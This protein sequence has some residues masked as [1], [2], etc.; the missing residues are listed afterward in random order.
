MFF[1]EVDDFG[2]AAGFEQAGT[3]LGQ[4]MNSRA[5]FEGRDFTH[6]RYAMDEGIIGGRVPV[7]DPNVVVVATRVE[8]G[9]C[10]LSGEQ[11]GFEKYVAL[12][13]VAFEELL[14]GGEVGVRF[15]KR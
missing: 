6:R 12:K 2:F 10:D 9:L 15:H 8:T 7:G 13:P 3:L 14:E 11:I 5:A 1:E 4:F